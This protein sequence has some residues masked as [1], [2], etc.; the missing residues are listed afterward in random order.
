M[1]LTADMASSVQEVLVVIGDTVTSGQQIMI[2]ESMKMEIPI[3]APLNGV[4]S[5]VNVINGQYV[6]AGAVLA[7]IEQNS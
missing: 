4:V 7:V 1:E 5:S 2:L 6:E 3:V